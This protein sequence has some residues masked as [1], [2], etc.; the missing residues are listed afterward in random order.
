[1]ER[2]TAGR[3]FRTV[4]LSVVALIGLGAIAVVALLGS[5]GPPDQTSRATEGVGQAAGTSTA[6]ESAVAQGPEIVGTVSVAEELRGRVSNDGTLFIVAR[7]GPGPPFAVKRVVT[8]SFPLTYRLGP[9]DLMVAGNV[10]EG[11]M[12]LSARLSKSGSAGPARP[13]DLEGERAGTVK[14]GARSVDIVLSRIR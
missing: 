10:F 12:L 14:V 6:S 9:E 13:G 3:G 4:V 2:Q 7:K 5:L 8:P 11:E 1:V